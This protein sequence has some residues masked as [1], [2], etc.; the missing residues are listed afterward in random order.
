MGRPTFKIDQVRLLGLREQKGMTQLVLAKKVAQR[1]GTP[2]VRSDKSLVRHYQRIEEKGNPSSKYAEA[3]ATVLGVSVPLLQGLEG[4]DPYYYLQHIQSL[5]KEQLDIG[6]NQALQGMLE[7]RAKDDEENALKY[8]AEDI[9]ERIEQ[10]QLVRNPDK[11]KNLIQLTGLSETDLLSPANVKGF[12]FISVRSPTYNCSEIVD[13]AST[14]GFRIGEIMRDFLSNWES[15]SVVRMRRDKPWIRIEIDRPRLRH[16]M[17]IDVTRCQPDATGLRWIDSSWLDAFFIEFPLIDT[18]YAHA[19]VVTDFSEKTS[20]GDLLRLR[21]VV[22]EHDGTYEKELRRMVIRGGIDEMPE[23]VK[24][25]F[26]KQGSSRILFM[27][28]LTVGLKDALMPHL[29]AHPASSWHVSTN[30]TA[31]AVEIKIKNP[32]YPSSFFAELRYR[33]T[34]AEEV[35]RNA[36]DRVPVREKDLVLL[37]SKIESWLAKGYSPTGDDELL[38]DF[39]PI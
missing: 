32:R 24:E 15:D 37:Q 11:I 22:I 12:W 16:P 9:A 29:A 30:G 5:L 13:G 21:L 4:P 34:L 10:A 38:P 36:Y 8:L 27:N 26:A 20:P 1:L 39:E 19:D 33:I 7:H 14:A 31:A 17:H 18:A 6:T 3:L 2:T 35:G 28:W 25:D 23:T